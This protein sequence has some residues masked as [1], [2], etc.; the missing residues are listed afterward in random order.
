MLW[1]WVGL[2]PLV[3]RAGA[4][5]A[6][7]AGVVQ[8]TVVVL[9]GTAVGDGGTTVTYGRIIG[10]GIPSTD[11]SGASSTPSRSSVDGGTV[12]VGRIL[13][14]VQTAPTSTTSSGVPT[15]RGG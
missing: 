6:G 3:V 15:T 1:R 13:G 12:R 9:G 2:P 7:I 14:R 5:G 11:G 10:G 4:Y 8:T